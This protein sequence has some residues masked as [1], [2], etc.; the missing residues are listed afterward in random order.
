MGFRDTAIDHGARAVTGLLGHV[1]RHQGPGRRDAEP[2]A[3]E[4]PALSHAEALLAKHKAAAVGSTST[5]AQS[6]PP[7]I[8]ASLFDQ[9]ED[10]AGPKQLLTAA[11]HAR[12]P[13]HVLLV[14][15]PG[16]GKSQLLQAIATLPGARYAVGGATSSSGLVAYL[17][18]QPETRFLVIDELDKADPSDLYALYSLMESGTV[19][20]LQHGHSESERRTVWVFAAANDASALPPA[21]ASRFVRIDFPP[22]TEA[23]TREITARVLVKREGLSSA[24]AREI[25]AATAARSRDP[26]D[27]I[28]VARLAG[29][30]GP[31]APLVEQVVPSKDPDAGVS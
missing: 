27:G 29:R 24:R 12:R 20:R 14:G 26:R 25:A 8:P 28:Q 23:Q 9:V 30:R 7:S 15:S 16:T 5:R 21:L 3:D 31:I 18:E 10:R 19:T 2:V 17:L 6:G 1:V 4:R 13:V 22:Y 11:L